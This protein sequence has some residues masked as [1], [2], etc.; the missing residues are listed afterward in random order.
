MEIRS[1]RKIILFLCIH[2]PCRTPGS[3]LTPHLKL[4]DTKLASGLPSSA[5]F[6]T[7]GEALMMENPSYWAS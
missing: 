2:P 6:I 3:I 4:E 1:V 7:L 5:P